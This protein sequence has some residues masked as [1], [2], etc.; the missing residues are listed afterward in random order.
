MQPLFT[1]SLLYLFIGF[2]CT[3][4]LK[5]EI[6]NDRCEMM[7]KK[8]D[9][10]NK[11]I[12][13]D[14][15]PSRL[16][17]TWISHECEIR[18][19][20]K[21]VIRKYSF[22]KNDSFLLLQY[23]Y[24]DESCSVATYT[25]VARGSV[26]ILS[27]SIVISGAVETSVQL[28]SVYLIPLN[29][30]VAH[31]FGRIM[32]ASCGGI[33]TKWRPYLVQLIYERSTNSSSS[34]P[35]DL[36]M[37][38][39][40]SNSLQSRLLRLRKRHTMDCLKSFEIDFSELKLLRV[41]IKRSN[42]AAKSLRNE[43][44]GEDKMRI[45]VELW[46]GGL[47][48]NIRFQKIQQAPNHLQSTSLLRAD[49]A[50]D[51]PIC[52]NVYRATEYS[53]PL[54]HQAPPLPAVIGG[55]WLSI[56][57]ESV[58]GGFWSK[59]FFQIYS[60]DSRWFARWTYYVDSTCSNSLYSINAAGNYVQ[61]VVRQR[62]DVE[63]SNTK[64]S[65]IEDLEKLR[66]N[67]VLNIHRHLFK[68]TEELNSLE[69]KQRQKMKI[70]Q[71]QE[72]I[73]GNFKV[74]KDKLPFGTSELE[75][76]ILEYSFI[77]VDKIIPINCKGTT[78]EIKHI[79][80]EAGL[81]TKNCILGTNFKAPAILKFKARIGLDWKGDYTLLLASWEDDL[82]E[83]P[84]H[85]CSEITSR[86]YFRE[87]WPLLFFRRGNRYDRFSRYRRDWFS[88]SF[89]TSLTSSSFMHYIILFLYWL[90]FFSYI[91]Y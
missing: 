64:T 58:D 68:D 89:A 73:I 69:L 15:T 31:K 79:R 65:N 55:V 61:R 38:D 19:G 87:S 17:S 3:V 75:L 26:K 14:N 90:H 42:S 41:E 27:P 66:K 59:R 28:D 80:N 39:L 60:D 57:C 29:R 12:I 47:A 81:W 51:C 6:E 43:N 85:Q 37:Y 77:P 18:A 44:N 1:V 56:R 53:P 30:Q 34:S 71:E 21:Y 86:N 48:R 9:S 40:N 62:R 22:F 82:W 83:A 23:H 36:N 88:S 46:L 74:Q 10:D 72:S 67:L 45:R 4:S 5:E 8:I 76:K 50:A 24:D 91:G 54:F 35:M 25:V 16:H 49:R 32:N 84:L 70:N 11:G 33:E 63:D 20:P 7:M 2:D 52:G 13:T 78:K